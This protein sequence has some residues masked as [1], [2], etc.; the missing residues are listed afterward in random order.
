MSA[1][2]ESCTD[3]YIN[4]NRFFIVLRGKK[5]RFVLL[6]ESSLYWK[7]PQFYVTFIVS[8]F[9]LNRVLQITVEAEANISLNH[10]RMLFYSMLSS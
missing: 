6:L 3:N 10:E 5:V 8:N 9:S 1:K 2:E 7:Q 4:E